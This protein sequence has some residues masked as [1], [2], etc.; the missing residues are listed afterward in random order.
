[1]NK[2]LNISSKII[3]YTII[4]AAPIQWVSIITIGSL[5]LKF[6]DVALIPVFLFLL[7]KKFRIYLVEFIIE[8][9][10][11]ITVFLLLMAVNYISTV[12]K[13]LS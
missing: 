5:S 4:M 9:R 1:M 7:V 13:V 10:L 8:Y 11:L 3:F 12:I 6:I 2:A